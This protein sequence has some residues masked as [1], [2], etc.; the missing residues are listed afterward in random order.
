MRRFPGDGGSIRVSR[1]GGFEPQWGRNG[2]LMFRSGDSVLV[3]TIAT[4]PSLAVTQVRQLFEIGPRTSLARSQYAVH[5]G[6]QRIAF[7]RRGTSG[8]LEIVVVT[9]WAEEVR[10][11]L[12]TKR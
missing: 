8:G 6:S 3:A 12:G 5:P 10:A 11:R 2:Q 7:Q 4:S 9:N 1:R